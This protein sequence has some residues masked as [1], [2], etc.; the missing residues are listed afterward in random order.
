MVLTKLKMIDTVCLIPVDYNENA[1]TFGL[2]VR[3]LNA[4]LQIWKPTKNVKLFFKLMYS[5]VNNV[6]Y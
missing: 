3:K 6:T 4:W 1:I 2:T 5:I